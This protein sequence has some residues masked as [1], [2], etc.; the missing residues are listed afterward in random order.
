MKKLLMVPSFVAGAVCASLL[1]T[2]ISARQPEP[3][4]RDAVP[5]YAAMMA[6]AKKYTE[7]GKHHKVL[8]R[9]L[10]Q[11]KTE[12]RFVM[13]GKTTPPEKGT[14]EFSWLMKDRWLKSEWSGKMM[15]RPLQ[16]FLILGYD[17]F[18]QSY[19]TTY[20]TNMDTAM[21]HSEGRMDPGGKALLSYGPLDEYLTGEVAKMVK[22]VWRFP[23]EDKMTF[24]VHDLPIG[25]HN[26]KVMEVAYSR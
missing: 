19:V 1:T 18:R 26:T 16:G 23:A 3:A 15:G 6:K 10:G 4:K 24:E 9:F 5:D 21:L 2:V 25:E 11:W 13:A 12:T 20:V 17:N 7:P 8:E 22:Y 14:A